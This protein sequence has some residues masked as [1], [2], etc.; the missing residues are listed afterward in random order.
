MFKSQESH[1]GPS[2]S[3]GPPQVVPV[4]CEQPGILQAHVLGLREDNL[5]GINKC[6]RCNLIEKVEYILLPNI[7]M[8][9]Q[10][11]QTPQLG[12]IEYRHHTKLLRIQWS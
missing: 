8:Y 4:L 11:E 2:G 6:R 3:P 5:G 9:L 7:L 12:R 1:S 10:V